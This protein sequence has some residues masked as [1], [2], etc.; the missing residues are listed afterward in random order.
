MTIRGKYRDALLPSKEIIKRRREDAALDDS[1]SQSPLPPKA[2]TVAPMTSCGPIC[3]HCD[4]CTTHYSKGG[5][6]V[7]SDYTEKSGDTSTVSTTE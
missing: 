5:R 4:L 1:P 3:P 6:H 2:D 7:C